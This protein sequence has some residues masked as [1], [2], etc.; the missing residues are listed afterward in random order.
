MTAS[1]PP[2]SE[3]APDV[4]A[5][6]LQATRRG[7]ADAARKLLEA[8]A[9]AVRQVVGRALGR[10]HPDCDDML[11]ESLLGFVR[12]LDSFRGECSVLHYARRIALWRVLEE[13]KRKQAQKRAPEIAAQR[14]PDRSAVDSRAHA[15]ALAARRREQL[16]AVLLSLRPEQAEALAMRHVL[17]YSVEEIAEATC[18]PANTVRSRLRLAKETLRMRITDNPLLSELDIRQ[19]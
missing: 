15:D 12:A 18:V 7:D 10:M 8:V 19:V 9:P 17:D 16:R 1:S 2:P 13:Q 11:Q 14:D 6:W 4:L 3:P 5:S